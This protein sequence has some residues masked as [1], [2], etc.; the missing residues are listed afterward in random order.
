M[1]L[2]KPF[3]IAILFLLA[4][5]V[6]TAQ[7]WG[8]RAGVNL[9][10]ASNGS[11]GKTD[12]RTGGYLGVYKEMTIISKL[13]FIQPEVQFSKQGF[14]TKTTDFDLDYIQVPVLAKVYLAKVVSFETGPQF[15][16]KISDKVSGSNNNPDFNTFDTAWAGGFSFNFP[17]GLAIN[18]RYIT[19]FTDVIKYD[20]HKSQVIQLGASFT[21]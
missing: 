12:I 21:F 13:L 10:S 3:L 5:N 14:N 20:S 16:F 8:V 17:M 11:F 7:G 1:K 15:G 6:A 9:A 19:S 2:A 18:A 4:A